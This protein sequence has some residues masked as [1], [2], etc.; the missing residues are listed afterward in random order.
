MLRGNMGDDDLL[1]FIAKSRQ[2]GKPDDQTVQQLLSVGWKKEKVEAAF[3][4]LQGGA[5]QA[6]STAPSTPPLQPQKAQPSP[7]QP[8]SAPQPQQQYP[9]QQP[10]Q[11]QQPS[12]SSIPT[13]PPLTPTSQPQPQ[14]QAT[15]KPIDLA[16]KKPFLQFSNPFAKKQQEQPP[17]D[18]VSVAPAQRQPEPQAPLQPSSPH[19]AI[20]LGQQPKPGGFTSNKLVMYAI[21]IILGVVLAI[22]IYYFLLMPMMLPAPTREEPRAAAPKQPSPQA[23]QANAS[24]G[25]NKSTSAP[26]QANASA[27]FSRLAAMGNGIGYKADYTAS[28]GSLEYPMTIY[29]KGPSMK[30]VD[31]SLGS[32][33]RSYILSGVA[34][35][36]TKAGTGWSCSESQDQASMEIEGS[37]ALENPSK[38][39]IEYN[40]TALLAGA[41]ATCFSA[42]AQAGSA[43][44]F[45]FSGEG[46]LLSSE[47]FQPGVATPA[48]SLT[49]QSYSLLQ[50][51]SAFELPAQGSQEGQPVQVQPP[52]E[53]QPLQQPE[54]PQEEPATGNTST[55][56]VE[57]VQQQNSTT[58]RNF[59]RTRKYY[60][61]YPYGLTQF[62]MGEGGEFYRAHSSEFWGGD[63]SSSR[64]GEGF[65][66]GSDMAAICSDVPCC[67]PRNEKEFSTRYDYFECGFEE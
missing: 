5:P 10:Q 33:S 42:K 19:N 26:A 7:N 44:R 61:S 16:E 3:A 40:G 30:R 65:A 21:T 60:S 12:P 15:A 59:T 2:R 36:C 57:F 27:E 39:T 67:I 14:P 49:A 8:Q 25:A 54:I 13:I 32:E 9:Y 34:Y 38:Y 45:C 1:E 50:D 41:N 4:R 46:A 56:A 17:A 53:E 62:C 63:C 58:E 31:T 29:S 37:D 35:G 48:I 55:I 23:Q 51:D 20:E 52:T 28:F 43:S 24:A 6:Q 47:I 66:Y 18:S 11:P 22:A 64:P